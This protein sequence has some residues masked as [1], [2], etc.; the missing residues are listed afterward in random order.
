MEG[1]RAKHSLA[2]AVAR[3][4]AGYLALDDGAFESG[5]ARLE[6]LLARGS[7]AKMVEG[8]LGA[9]RGGAPGAPQ[10]SCGLPCLPLP[11]GQEMMRPEERRELA[12]RVR[13]RVGP[14]AARIIER[15]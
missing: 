13:A 4:V 11:C 14:L 12:A 8:C 6:A 10:R 1:R 15:L 7:Y 2:A 9:G 3:I 5:A